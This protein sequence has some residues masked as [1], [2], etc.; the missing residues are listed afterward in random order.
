MTMCEAAVIVGL[1]SGTVGQSVLWF[2]VEVLVDANS[3]GMSQP[4]LCY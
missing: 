4:L 1:G 2:V 3:L